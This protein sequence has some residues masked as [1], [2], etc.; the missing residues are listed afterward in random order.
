M[1]TEQD[2][3]KIVLKSMSK[4]RYKAALKELNNIPLFKADGNYPLSLDVRAVM[5]NEGSIGLAKLLRDTFRFDLTDPNVKDTPSRVASMWVNELMVGRYT[6]KPRLEAFPVE[7]KHLSKHS[8]EMLHEDASVLEYDGIII[9]KID[10]RSLC[11]HHLMPFF[12]DGK[13]SFALVAYIPTT[14]F[15][16]ISKIQR[17]SNWYGARPSLQEQLTWSIYKE[18]CDTLGT[19]DVFVIMKNITHTC[20]TLRGAKTEDGSTTTMFYGGK[21][22]DIK[23]R[24]EVINLAA[25]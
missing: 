6:D 21:F 14:K 2:K 23:K 25:D 22:K 4:K 15:L 8:I 1:L 18:M 9:K 12:S 24:N 11:S 16:G 5:A 3:L 10:V 20:E 7:E 17:L 19:D 13:K